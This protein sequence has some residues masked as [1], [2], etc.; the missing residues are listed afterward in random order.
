MKH[1]AKIKRQNF[2]LKLEL[3]IRRD[4]PTNIDVDGREKMTANADKI[5]RAERMIQE[6][7]NAHH[8]T[9]TI[10]R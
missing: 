1:I 9:L 3:H 2:D 7:R 6:V 5:H 4:I 10:E 8:P